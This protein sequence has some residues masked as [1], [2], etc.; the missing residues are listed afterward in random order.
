MVKIVITLDM[1]CGCHEED[2]ADK[3]IKNILVR[4]EQGWTETPVNIKKEY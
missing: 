1:P 3:I 2:E 4:A